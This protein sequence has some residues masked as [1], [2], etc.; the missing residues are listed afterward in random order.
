MI[1]EIFKHTQRSYFQI[2][3]ILMILKYCPVPIQTSDFL[4]EKLL[5]YCKLFSGKFTVE[6]G[7]IEVCTSTGQYLSI[8]CKQND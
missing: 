1:F 4:D 3:K 5:F 8:Y 6:L 2:F 7:K